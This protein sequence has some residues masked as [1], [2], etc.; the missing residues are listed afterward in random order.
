MEEVIKLRDPTKTRFNK[1]EKL[2][3][4][5]IELEKGVV[6]SVPWLRKMKNCYMIVGVYMRHIRIYIQI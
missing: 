5:G 1:Q 3:R 4:D 6:I 2:Y